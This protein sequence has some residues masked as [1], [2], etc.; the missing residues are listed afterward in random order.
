M[1]LSGGKGVYILNNMYALP[2]CA[3]GLFFH[4]VCVIDCCRVISKV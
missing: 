3:W 4:Y 1:K 2:M